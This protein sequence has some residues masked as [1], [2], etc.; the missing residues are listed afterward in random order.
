MLTKLKNRL[1]HKSVQIREL[2]LVVMSNLA[3]AAV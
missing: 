1:S 3:Y 2:L